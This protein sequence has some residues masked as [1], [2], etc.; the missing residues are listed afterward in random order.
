[1]S[2]VDAGYAIV[3][4]VLAAYSAWVLR[5]RRILSRALPAKPANPADQWH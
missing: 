4:V 5:R 1:M 3:G 2:Y